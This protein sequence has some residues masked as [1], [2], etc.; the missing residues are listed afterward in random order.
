MFI[1]CYTFNSIVFGVL[2]LLFI[3][4]QYDFCSDDIFFPKISVW[5]KDMGHGA[6]GRGRRAGGVGQIK[7]HDEPDVLRVRQK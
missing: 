4:C 7:T 1:I 6:G 2:L 5:G 3:I